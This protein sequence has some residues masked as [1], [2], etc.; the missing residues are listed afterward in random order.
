MRLLSGSTTSLFQE[1]RGTASHLFVF[2]GLNHTEANYALLTQ[3]AR[4]VKEILGDEV[5]V[6][7]IVSQDSKR[8]SNDW[9]GSLLLDPEHVLHTRYGAASPSLYFVRPDGYIGFYCQPIQE[10]PLL[11]YLE[12]WFV[13]SKEEVSMGETARA[14][15]RR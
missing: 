1:F 7:L 6:S 15:R 10:K 2:D 4:R 11:E 8:V 14:Y 5:K 12:R 3:T 13:C 9:D